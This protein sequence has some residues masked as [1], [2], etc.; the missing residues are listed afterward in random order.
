VDF[1]LP[2]EVTEARRE[3]RA[4]VD[5]HV[6]P[7]LQDWMRRGEVP[8]RLFL[9]L[10]EDGWLGFVRKEGALLE[11]SSLEQAVISEELARLSPGVAVTALVQV[12]LGLKSLVLFGSGPLKERYRDAAV[13]GKTL[14]CLGNTESGAGSDVA[15][16]RTQA[17][18][19]EGGWILNGAK[20]FVTNG[21]IADLAVVTAVSDPEAHKNR[22][23]SMFLVDL[24]SPGVSRTKLDK[25]VWIPSD[26]TRLGFEE[27]LVPE[28]NLVGVQGRG[29]Q[30][31]LDVFTHSRVIIAAMTLGTAAGA[32]ELGLDRAASREVFGQ[33]LI[34]FQAKSFEVASFFAR[35]EAVRLAVWRACRTMDEGKEFRLESSVAKYLAVELAREI[36]P[37][38]ADLFGASSVVFEHPIHKY[39]MDGWASSLGEGTQDIQKL[40]IFRELMRNRMED[41][42]SSPEE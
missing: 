19:V 8:R 6:R 17:R 31:V 20:A 23:I 10:G 35:L 26:L 34:D 13:R 1:S 25:R 39:P 33:R 32:F 38:A 42:E 9:E 15:A 18:R 27:V 21:Y 3:F 11:R 29:L 5:R 36:C 2:N 28:G 16:V 24:N 14:I 40:I 30:Q 4:F 41:R 37:W 12:S 7:H 22:R